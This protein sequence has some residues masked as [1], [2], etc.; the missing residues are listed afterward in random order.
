[1]VRDLIRERL[2]QPRQGRSAFE[3]ALEM[4]I[5]G[6][7]ADVRGDVAKNHSSYLRDTQC[8]KRIA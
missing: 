8:V 6:M 1:M 3:I 4:G 5:V 7:D 2:A